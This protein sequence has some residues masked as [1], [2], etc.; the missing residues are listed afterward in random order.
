MQNVDVALAGAVL[1]VSLLMLG[2]VGM[3]RRDVIGLLTL[4]MTAMAAGSMAILLRQ[5]APNSGVAKGVSIILLA[6]GF[7][8]PM[9]A[10]LTGRNKRGSGDDPDRSVSAPKL[11]PFTRAILKMSK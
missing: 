9:I 2:R 4:I 5:L 8:F 7:V 6:I 11:D 3:V 1:V 10:L